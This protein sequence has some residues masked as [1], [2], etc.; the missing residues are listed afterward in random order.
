MGE[1]IS[2]TR[3]EVITFPIP[4]EV[5]SI[6][7]DLNGLCPHCGKNDGCLNIERISFGVC[8]EHK[9]KWQI[10]S[11]SIVNTETPE[12][13]KKN[14]DVLSHYEEVESFWIAPF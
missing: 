14:I 6:E 13:W 8:H 9:T 3:K 1:V 2:I 10:F 11:N 7:D 5:D 4:E 12:D